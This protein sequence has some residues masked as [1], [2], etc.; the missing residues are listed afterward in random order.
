MLNDNSPRWDLTLALLVDR[1]RA[2]CLRIELWDFDDAPQVRVCACACACARVCVR[3]CSLVDAPQ[4]QC[5]DFLGM[6][7][8][9]GLG[10][11]ALPSWGAEAAQY[12]LV[13]DTEQD[14]VIHGSTHSY[15]STYNDAVGGHVCL[16]CS[17]RPQPSGHEAA[18]LADTR[19]EAAAPTDTRR[20]TAGGAAAAEQQEQLPGKAAA[21]PGGRQHVRSVLGSWVGAPPAPFHP[22]LVPHRVPH[23]FY[24][25]SWY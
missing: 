6:H 24:P 21:A 3:V 15:R 13:R 25:R 8:F 1:Q 9:E 7:V 16:H 4:D 10:C 11:A 2:N 14:G 5:D 19:R 23:G 18:G 12:E 20:E 17:S 22:F